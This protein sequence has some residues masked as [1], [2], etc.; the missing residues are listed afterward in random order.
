MTLYCNFNVTCQYPISYTVCSGENDYT[1]YS[2]N[3]FHLSYRTYSI[4]KLLE[5]SFCLNL[6]GIL[7]LL[8]K[9]HE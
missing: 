9:L 7:S 5:N 4:Y 6:Y 8:L 2:L 1:E 3:P